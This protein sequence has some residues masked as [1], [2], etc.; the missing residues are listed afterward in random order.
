[1]GQAKARRQQR[2]QAMRQAVLDQSERWAQP[3]SDLEA[4]WCREIA[5]AGRAPTWRH[6]TE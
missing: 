5:G 1:M 6:G 4:E 3:G 2:L